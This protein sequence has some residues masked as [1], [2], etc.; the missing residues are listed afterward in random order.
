[1]VAHSRY[2]NCFNMKSIFVSI[3]LLWSVCLFAQTAQPP[4]D[5]VSIKGSWVLAPVLASDTATGKLPSI[6]FNPAQG[7]FTGFT[8]CNLMSGHLNI[9]GSRLTF[10]EHIMA[11]KMACEGYNEKQ[12][13]DNL[14]RVTGYKIEDGTLILLNGQTPLSKWKRLA[15]VN[16]L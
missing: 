3:V 7:S 8:G 2:K 9:Q 11:T 14:L 4:Y 16:S 1:M 15:A 10:D 6:Q 5:T 12:F 13:M